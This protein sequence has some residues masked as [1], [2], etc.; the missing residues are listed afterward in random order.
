MDEGFADYFSC[1]FTNDSQLGEGFSPSP[2]NLDNTLQYPYPYSGGAHQNGQ[3]IAGAVWDLRTDFGLVPNDVDKLA[4][5]AL[6]I[7][8][9]NP[10]GRSFIP[11]PARIVLRGIPI[12]AS[13]AARVSGPGNGAPEASIIMDLNIHFLEQTKVC[14][15]VAN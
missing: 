9:T 13:I 3:I 1:A 12:W 8:T 11:E 14:R 7:M 6:N 10:Y 5:E 2:R 4:F 15:S